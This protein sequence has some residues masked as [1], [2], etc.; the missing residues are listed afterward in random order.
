MI[1]ISTTPGL[2]PALESECRALGWAPRRLIG[3]T[4][5]EG[6]PGIH[7]EANLRQRTASRVLLRLA[8]LDA[9]AP[10]RLE[11]ALAEIDLSPHRGDQR[12]RVSV[13]SRAS[14]IRAGAVEAIARR[15]WGAAARE[16]GFA[17][18]DLHLRVEGTRCTVSVD[19]SGELLYRRGY[20]QEVS[21]APLRE[22]LAAGMLILAGFEGQ[23]PLVDPM[24]GS[25][26]LAIEAALI[27]SGRAPGIQRRFAFERWPS[28]DERD[29]AR[30]RDRARSEEREPSHP[31]YASDLNAGALGTA[32]RN[33][34]RA[35]V[36]E[37]IR[38]ARGDVAQLAPPGS[39]GWL[40][41]NLPFGKRVGERASL[42][43]LYAKVGEAVGRSKG[44]QVA[45]LVERERSGTS[46]PLAKVQRFELDNGG[47]ACTLVSGLS[48]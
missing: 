13:A 23:A 11:R 20:R 37:M 1:F 22:T 21:R 26:T 27:A 41:A 35:G 43:S 19:T 9:D 15:V 16:R 4:Q 14:R 7:Q 18:L 24:C 28:F 46:F 38:F 5:V 6:E 30:R 29:W 10:A 40:V 42:A 44:W 25:G 34:R 33:A 8:E 2:E 32:K 36:L 39:R 31:I 3:G 48:A 47:L 17:D 12:L 45:L